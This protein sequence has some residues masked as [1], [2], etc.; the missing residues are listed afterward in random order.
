MSTPV[1]RDQYVYMHLG[2]Q[3][4]TCIDLANG[5]TRWTSEPFGK[6]SSMI[7]QGDKVLALDQRGELVMF[8]ASPDR[9]ELLGQVRVSDQETWAHLAAA[10]DELFVRELNAISAFRF[11]TR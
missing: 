7:V 5:E 2:N 8:R 10:G 6:Y 11:G 3:R 1:V 9:F 4:F